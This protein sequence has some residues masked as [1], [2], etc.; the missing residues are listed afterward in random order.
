MPG[1]AFPLA[2][3]IGRVPSMTVPLDATQEQRF[4]RLMEEIVMVDLHQHPLVWPESTEHFVEYLR[5]GDYQWGYQAAKHGG[6]AAVA[7]ANVFRG[8]LHSPDISYIAFADLVDEIGMM[9]ADL[10]Q[11]PEALKV[12]S[13]DAIVNARQQGKVGIL[14]TVEHLAIGESLQH[15]DVLYA[16]GV[17]IA[18]L[19]Y[20]R[21][22]AIGCGLQERHDPGL[23]DFGI[24]VV[25]RMN[26][27]GMAVDVSHAGFRTA[28]DASQ[29]SQ[30]P[31]IYSH[32]AAH[33]LRPTWRTRKDEELVA[34]ARKGGL[35]AITA[36]P[37]SLSDDPRQ[38]ITCVLDHY[39]YMVRLVGADHVAIGT[40]TLVGDHVGFHHTMMGADRATLPAPY[41][42][43]LE[44]PADGKNIIRGLIARGHSDAHIKKIAGGNALNFLRRVMA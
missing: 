2:K 8:M 6:W 18:G 1:N 20:N 28:M 29:H 7:T 27:L 35:I 10:S 40:D 36:V 38:N 43:G 13:A 32:N 9:L 21:Q 15:V 5:H 26:D 39:D 30:V 17:R 4:Q 14:P 31:I 44:S 11:H 16:L 41:L 24:A 25:R 19:T 23:S 12:T 33:T 3:Q 34:C 37:N 22:N 42:D